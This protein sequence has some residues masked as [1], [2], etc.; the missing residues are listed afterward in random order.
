MP[1]RKPTWEAVEDAVLENVFDDTERAWKLSRV[2]KMNAEI[3]SERR[4][5]EISERRLNYEIE[6]DRAEVM[7]RLGDAI[8][9]L[10]RDS[11]GTD[12]GLKIAQIINEAS[13]EVDK[14]YAEE[15][16]KA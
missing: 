15:E 11:R 16:G 13:E 6:E 4:R 5:I 3:K 7:A 2:L 9:R 10:V 14:Y 12:E 1:K 8:V